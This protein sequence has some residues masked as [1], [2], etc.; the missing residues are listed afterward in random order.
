MRA[1]IPDDTRAAGNGHMLL[2]RIRDRYA[3]LS[4][5]ERRLADLILSFPGEIA[6]YTAS[7]LATMAG[8][9]NAAVTRFVQRI[10]FQ[11]F[12]EMRL[13]SRE[14]VKSGSPLYF[15]HHDAADATVGVTARHLDQTVESFRQTLKGLPDSLIEE[16]AESVV[17]ARRVWLVGFRHSHFLAAYLHWQIDHVRGEVRLLPRGGNTMGESLVDLGE[18][19]VA[20]AVAL[21]RVPRAL[22]PLLA[23]MRT[24]GA[25]LAVITDFSVAGDYDADWVLRCDTRTASPVDNHATVLAVGQALLDRIIAR[26]GPAAAERFARIDELHNEIGEL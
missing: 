16:V 6:G 20:V 24:A 12:E 21:R 4:P 22:E 1:P 5:V 25:R 13:L 8:I 19:D 26:A 15:L 14:G 7:E 23:T 3:A 10:G 17:A 9:S 18:G 11:N 2:G